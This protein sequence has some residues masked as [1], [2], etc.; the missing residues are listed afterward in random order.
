[1][2]CR[3]SALWSLLIHVEDVWG[4]T[5]ATRAAMLSNSIRKHEKNTNKRSRKKSYEKFKEEELMLSCGGVGCCQ[6]RL[7]ERGTCYLSW[8]LEGRGDIHQIWVGVHFR[9]EGQ[10]VFHR[11][12][13]QRSPFRL[14]Y[15]ECESIV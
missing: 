4:P 3:T 9:S 6:R 8:V 15:K 14:K 11:N 13:G 12:E 1:M 5:S 2:A 7:H 10:H